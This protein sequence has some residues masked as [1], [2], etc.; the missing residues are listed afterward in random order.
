MLIAF[1]ALIAMVNGGF[2]KIHSMVECSPHRCS[3]YSASCSRPLRGCSA[4][5]GK[6]A[7]DCQLLGE[8]LSPTNSSIHRLGQNQ[9]AAYGIIHDCHLRP[10]RLCEFQLDRIQLVDRRTRPH[11]KVPGELECGRDAAQWQ[12]LC[13]HVLPVC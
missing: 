12:T 8:R 6:I 2:N 5:R 7:R 4:C 13:R 9:I 10:L 1:L 11:A 3:S